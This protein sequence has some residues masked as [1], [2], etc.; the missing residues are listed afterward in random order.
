MEVSAMSGPVGLYLA[1][2]LM[3]LPAAVGCA[4]VG[5]RGSG[6][7]AGLVAIAAIGASFAL[8]LVGAVTFLRASN[9][10]TDT[11]APVWRASWDWVA[12]GGSLGPGGAL[13]LPV[14]M[15]IDNLTVLLFVVVTSIALAVVVYAL[16]SM[17]DEPRLATFYAEVT[18]F[19]AAMLGLLAAADLFTLFVCWELVGF[20]SYLLVGFWADHEINARAANKAFLVNRVG[21]VGM[22][23]GLG[24]LWANLGTLD[25]ATM[26]SLVH[27]SGLI[28]DTALTVAGLGLVVGALAKSAQFPLHVWLPDAMAGPTPA[29]ALIH[30]ATMVAAGVYL[31][32]RVFPLLT[33]EV[34]LVVAY[35]GAGTLI[36]AASIALVQDDYKKVL[37]YST[38]SQLG[39]MMVGLGGGRARGGLVPPGHACLLQGDPVPGSRERLRRDAHLQAAGSGRALPSDEDDL[40]GDAGGDDGHRRGADLQRVRLEGRHPGLD[41]PICP[42]SPRAP[43]LVRGPG[44]RVGPD[45]LLHVPRLVP[46]L[47]G[48]PPDRR[49]RAGG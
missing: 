18:L 15:A 10:L 36:L 39:F 46:D 2:I 40:A 23:V 13:A 25:F 29:S 8:S 30:A 37:A 3:P 1:T 6:R 24:L 22:L 47:L 17:R 9:G 33:P 26:N 16:G 42:G 43:A 28:S 32:A 21:D 44:G 4:I 49:R 20:C 31:I 12:L 14:G 45:R 27:G 48:N 7:A 35:T 19:V 34:L 11:P 41:A 38:I 5:K